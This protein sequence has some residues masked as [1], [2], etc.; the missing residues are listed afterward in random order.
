M[1]RDEAWKESKERNILV[2]RGFGVLV[3]YSLLL[4][5]GRLQL[6]ALLVVWEQRPVWYSATMPR[7]TPRSEYCVYNNLPISPLT[8]LCYK[9]GTW[10]CT[11]V[12]LIILGGT[13]NDPGSTACTANHWGCQRSRY[14]S[15]KTSSLTRE[16]FPR[17]SILYRN[18]DPSS[19]YVTFVRS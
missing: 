19:N 7:L 17:L 11:L 13:T 12:F 3:G 18:T 6:A 14:K 8:I 4:I 16:N 5:T 2:F 15:C 1:R 10:P 9:K